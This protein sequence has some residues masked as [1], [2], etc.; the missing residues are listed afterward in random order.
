MPVKVP[1]HGV[2]IQ[3][4]DDEGNL[5][6]IHPPIGKPFEFTDKEVSVFEK[7]GMKTLKEPP[8]GETPVK[9]EDLVGNMDHAD[10]PQAAPVEEDKAPVK[11]A[12][13]PTGKKPAKADDEDDG[14]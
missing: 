3:R 10:P 11:P 2:T 6:N 12:A 8:K 9:A 13:K 14:L 7:S 1:L 4:K 5:R